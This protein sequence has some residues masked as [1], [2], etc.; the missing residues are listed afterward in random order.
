MFVVLVI[1]DL[2]YTLMPF[3]IHSE[4]CQRN[5]LPVVVEVNPIVRLIAALKRATLKNGDPILAET[6]LDEIINS[7]FSN[8]YV[9]AIN[10]EFCEDLVVVAIQSYRYK[11]LQAFQKALKLIRNICSSPG[12]MDNLCKAGMILYVR[13]LFQF[14]IIS[15]HVQLF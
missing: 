9:F 11:N 4:I 3:V 2:C 15:S 7:F 8:Y 5:V 12:G 6:T 13:V 10:P 1:S 14:T